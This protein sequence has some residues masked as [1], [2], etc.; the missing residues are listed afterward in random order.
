MWYP[1]IEILKDGNI[2]ILAG[3]WRWPIIQNSK[4]NI[5]KLKIP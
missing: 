2:E 5:Q 4:F 3:A 1:K